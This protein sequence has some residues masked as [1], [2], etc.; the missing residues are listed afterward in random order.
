MR[1]TTDVVDCMVAIRLV[2]ESMDVKCSGGTEKMFGAELHGL[3]DTADNECAEGIDRYFEHL[4]QSFPGK[5]RGHRMR[6]E[7]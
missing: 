3:A 1:D 4:G 6:S 2:E 5:G 7:E